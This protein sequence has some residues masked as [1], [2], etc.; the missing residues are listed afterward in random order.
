[1]SFERAIIR[2]HVLDILTKLAIAL[3]TDRFSDTH[4]ICTTRVIV[5]NIRTFRRNH[6]RIDQK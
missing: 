2:L 4:F 3:I 1:M 6:R 5:D